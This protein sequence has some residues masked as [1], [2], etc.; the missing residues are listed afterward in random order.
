MRQKCESSQWHFYLF[1]CILWLLFVVA[2]VNNL[3]DFMTISCVNKKVLIRLFSHF[4]GFNMNTT[5]L[6]LTSIENIIAASPYKPLEQGE[7]KRRKNKYA[8]CF[9]K[10]C[11]IEWN[12][13]FKWSRGLGVRKLIIKWHKYVNTSHWETT[14]KGTQN[15]CV[16]FFCEASSG[17][18]FQ[19]LQI[20]ITH[21]LNSYWWN[22]G[23][24]KFVFIGRCVLMA[25]KFY[26]PLNVSVPRTIFTPKI[27][28]NWT[29]IWQLKMFKVEIE[30]LF[31]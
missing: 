2:F 24:S 13:W 12:K 17:A 4:K 31:L 10:L 5:E 6:L 25:C 18:V 9:H 23:I 16:F 21:T 29:K 14:N 19:S 28:Y 1:F 15:S 26:L 22:V 7:K 30:S 11:L 8:F 20:P 27:N 3:F